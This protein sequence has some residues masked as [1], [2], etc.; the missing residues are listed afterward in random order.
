MI[1]PAEYSHIVGI[2]DDVRPEDKAELW[3][4]NYSSPERT[5]KLGLDVSSRAFTGMVDDVPV[6]MWGVVTDS[7]IFRSGIPWM[8]CS[9]GVE[10]V[11]K[12]FLKESKPL[13]VKLCDGYDRLDNYVDARNTRTMGWLKWM[14]FEFSEEPEPYGVLQVPFYKFWWVRDV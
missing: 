8:V 4:T 11:A 12:T 9:K 13:M 10:R 1:I 5:M 6:C 14:G 7:V 3:A 2:A